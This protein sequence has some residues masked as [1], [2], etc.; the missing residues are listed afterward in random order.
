MKFGRKDFQLAFKT[1]TDANKAKFKKEC[2]Q[3]EIYHAT[4]T[5]VFYIAEVTAGLND[6]TLSQFGA[7]PFTN[8]Y[9]VEFDQVDDFVSFG[10][11]TALN[12]ASAFSISV[13]YKKFGGLNAGMMLGTGTGSAGFYIQHYHDNKIYIGF[14]STFASVSATQDTNWHHVAYVTDSG[15]HKLYWDGNDMGLGGTPPLTTGSSLGNTFYLGKWNTYNLLFGGNIDE[16]SIFDSA[17]TATDIS[18]LRGGASAGTLGVPAD[19]SSLNPV[20]WWRMGDGSDGS[21]NA[22][23]TVVGGLPQIYNVAT[24]GSGNR[25][26]GIDGSMTNI[27]SPNGIVT[28][29]PS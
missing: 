16:L 1:G 18:T 5:G 7:T 28:D 21:G 14:G 22:D 15:T 13:W 11:V 27:A 10:S 9:S 4:D 8:Q 20:G 17:L 23:G 2:V 26:T 25:I 6:A 12:S 24:D 29:V 3:G 19:I